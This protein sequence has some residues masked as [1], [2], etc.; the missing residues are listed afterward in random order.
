MS[1]RL[2]TTKANAEKPETSAEETSEAKEETPTVSE[3]ELKL[4][5]E[6]AKLVEN[7]KELDV[8]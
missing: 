5:A 8:G 1:F 3:N 2:C 7:L 6:N 4:Q